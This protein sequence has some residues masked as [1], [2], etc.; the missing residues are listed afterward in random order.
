MRS[1]LIIRESLSRYQQK[2]KLNFTSREVGLEREI[3]LS[4][5]ASNSFEVPV[6]YSELSDSELLDNT[7]CYYQL[8]GTMPHKIFHAPKAGCFAGY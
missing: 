3:K 6:L 5:Q 1:S 4:R 8:T 7:R 2:L